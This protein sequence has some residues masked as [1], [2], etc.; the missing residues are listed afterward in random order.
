MHNRRQHNLVSSSNHSNSIIS[1]SSIISD[2]S[3]ANNSHYSSNIVQ[4][5]DSMNN[6]RRV[7]PQD[8]S[9]NSQYGLMSEHN[10]EALALVDHIKQM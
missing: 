10:L 6:L 2:S 1:N 3:I 8:S 4:Y 9:N 7:A 5:W